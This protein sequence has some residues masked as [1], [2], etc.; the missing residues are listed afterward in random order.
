MGFESFLGPAASTGW[1]T[2]MAA[3]SLRIEGMHC[4]ACIRR[5]TH[6]IATAGPFEVDQVRIGAA[7]FEAPEGTQ[8][9]AEGAAIATLAKAGFA[10]HPEP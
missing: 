7:S 9:E 1:G 3:V 10:A 8:K 2:S 4:G 5:V 6:A